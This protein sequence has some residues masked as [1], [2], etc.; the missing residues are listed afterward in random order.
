MEETRFF[1]II[2]HFFVDEG[3]SNRRK[4]TKITPATTTTTGLV[5]LPLNIKGKEGRFSSLFFFAGK[6]R[7]FHFFFFPHRHES[8]V[9]A[10]LVPLN[11]HG[12]GAQ[13]ADLQI[14]ININIIKYF[15]AKGVSFA[16]T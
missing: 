9:S 11:D 7:T 6:P 2:F 13:W 12:A 8:V 14:Q 1:A 15:Y 5:F 16:L 3:K 4:K 10:G